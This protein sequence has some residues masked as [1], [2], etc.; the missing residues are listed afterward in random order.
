MARGDGD[1]VGRNDL[2]GEQQ[3]ERRADCAQQPVAEIRLLSRFHGIDAGRLEDV[4]AREAGLNSPN[5]TM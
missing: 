1:I 3:P 4:E 5:Q 2:I